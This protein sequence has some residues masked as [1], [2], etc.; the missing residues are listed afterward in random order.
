MR[1]GGEQRARKRDV[2]EKRNL[3][4]SA[5]CGATCSGVGIGG[6]APVTEFAS[7]NTLEW[8]LP[9]LLALRNKFSSF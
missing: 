6:L 3:C 1:A 7:G 4:N 2:V 8:D 5:G 9:R